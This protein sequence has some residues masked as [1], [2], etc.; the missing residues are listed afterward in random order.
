[1]V[2]FDISP[3][4]QLEQI[5]NIAEF[6]EKAVKIQPGFISATLHRSIDGKRIVNYAQWKTKEAYEKAFSNSK[7]VNYKKNPFRHAR[8][9]PHVYEVYYNAESM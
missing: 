5:A 9:D 4:H 6:I 2:H 1:M 3:E 7:I 8:P